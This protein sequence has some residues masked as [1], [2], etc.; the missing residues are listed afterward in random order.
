[1]DY[2]RS[3]YHIQSTQNVIENCDH[4]LL[5][6]LDLLGVMKQF[7][8]V[9]LKILHHDENVGVLAIIGATNDIEKLDGGDVVSDARKLA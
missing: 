6:K 2:V 7:C 9:S 1:M 3:V 5:S 4:M 8:K